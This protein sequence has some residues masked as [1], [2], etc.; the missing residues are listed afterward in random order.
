MKFW[1]GITDGDWFNHLARRQPD[2]VNFWQPGGGRRFRAIE[3]GG[4]FLFKLHSPD[5][6]IAGGGF[7]VRNTALPVHLAWEAFG[8]NNGVS[9]LPGL[10]ERIAR[11]RKDASEANPVIGCNILTQ[12]F[13]LERHEWIPAPASWAPNIVT[14]KT[15]D[16]SEDEGAALFEAVQARLHNKWPHIEEQAAHEQ[17]RYGKAFL[18]RARLGQGAFQILV[19]DAYHRRCAI[20]GERTLPALEAAHIKPHSDS[21]PNHT[22]NGLL[23]R[24]DIHRLF[25]TGYI[26]VTPELRIEVSRRIR[27]EFENG[28][29]YYRHHGQQLAVMPEEGWQRPDRTY[30]EYHNERVYRG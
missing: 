7:F 18:T 9:S 23:L 22:D 21:G 4:L 12:P 19:T 10:M 27:E 1:V 25:D 17:A 8:Q 16:T 14:G 26:T 24:S 15:F 5:N 13:F 28:R 20:S 11:Y 3:P 2:E 6:Y 29:D 30:I